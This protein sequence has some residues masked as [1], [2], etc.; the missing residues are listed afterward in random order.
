MQQQTLC[1]GR[2][3]HQLFADMNTDLKEALET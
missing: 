1:K 3:L 2:G